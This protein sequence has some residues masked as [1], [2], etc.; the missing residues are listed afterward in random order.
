MPVWQREIGMSLGA[1]YQTRIFNIVK[2][3]P[4]SQNVGRIE[5]S[6]AG[7]N[8]PRSDS[9]PSPSFPEQRVLV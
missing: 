3:N 7:I 5:G 1:E 2:R 4:K 9:V 8:M 6:H